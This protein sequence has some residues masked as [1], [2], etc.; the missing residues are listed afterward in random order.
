MIEGEILSFQ[1]KY[2]VRFTSISDGEDFA[3]EHHAYIE[4]SNDTDKFNRAYLF[5]KRNI[6]NDLL[7]DERI[8]QFNLLK[9]D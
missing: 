4:W 7:E 1:F 5:C 2:Q 9:L 3:A 8:L 6:Y